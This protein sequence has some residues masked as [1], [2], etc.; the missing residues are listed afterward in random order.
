MEDELL[1]I[2]EVARFL[3]VS[4]GHVYK[5]MR[6]GKLPVIRVGKK[7]TRIERSDLLAF[8][9]RHKTGAPSGEED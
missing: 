6:Q 2:E 7:Y 5:L 3:K 8:I 9:Q 4:E 1:T